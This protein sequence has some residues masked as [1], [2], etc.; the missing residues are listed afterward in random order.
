MK[1]KL[2]LVFSA[3]ATLAQPQGW[4]QTFGSASND[5]GNTVLQTSD[6]GYLGLGT[7]GTNMTSG[8]SGLLNGSGANYL[9]KTDS[10]GNLQWSKSWGWF[11][12]LDG[13]HSNPKGMG[14]INCTLRQTADGGFIIAGTDTSLLNCWNCYLLVK[15][16][17]NG[18]TVWTK[19]YPHNSSATTGDAGSYEVVQESGGG[20]VMIGR[21]L[22]NGNSDRI[23]AIRTDANGNELLRKDIYSATGNT[24]RP[25]GLEP[26]KNN[27]Y[28]VAAV[29][30]GGAILM[31]L[32][33]AFDT[34][35]TRKYKVGFFQ[36]FDQTI[37][38]GFIL[39]GRSYI[40][41]YTAFAISIIKVN[42][43]GD[44]LWTRQ[45]ADSSIDVTSVKQVS[46]GGYIL[47]GSFYG[48]DAFGGPT[49]DTQL[50]LLKLDASGN[51]LWK[52]K[53]GG[54]AED[55]GNSVRQTN[56][57]GFILTGTTNS[58]G[59]GDYDLYLIKTDSLGNA[60][61]MATAILHPTGAKNEI[62][63]FP[64]PSNGFFNIRSGTGI[65]QVEITDLVGKTT[66]RAIND[67][68]LTTWTIDL[69]Q[70]PK[71][72]YFYK[73]LLVGEK[74]SAGKIIIE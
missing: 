60:P 51:K 18:D 46:D 64:N 32:N 12:I 41:N 7:T 70:Q 28:V 52:K 37:D 26:L 20:Y 23:G 72:V 2:L 25:I 35:W 15:L 63:V 4:Q 69:R 11:H 22:Q 58:F 62:E 49:T 34:T 73:V 47:T 42:S 57:G 71:G 66:L 1:I 45:Y 24:V 27:R 54:S 43:N 53:Y 38:S 10:Y 56:D 9:V 68:P 36:D 14:N 13:P 40:N 21:H 31:K 3:V 59:A 55:W 39:V 44:T 50:L 48:T 16:D 33:S 29:D 67:S 30:T 65:F 19:T 61:K 5:I 74:S 6:G 17:Q 8:T